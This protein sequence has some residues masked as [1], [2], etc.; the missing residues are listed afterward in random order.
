[1]PSCTERQGGAG[2]P[3]LHRAPIHLFGDGAPSRRPAWAGTPRLHVLLLLALAACGPKPAAPPTATASNPAAAAATSLTVLYTCDTRGNVRACDCTGGS[4]GG[5]ARR[6]TFVKNNAVPGGLLVDVGNNAAGPR[7]WEQTDF[8]FLL[9]G[10]AQMG[11]DAVNIGHGEAQL[12]LDVLR[13]LGTNCPALISA[14]LVDEKG[15]PVFPPYRIVRRPDGLRVGII[16][17]MDP[18]LPGPPGAGLRVLGADEAIARHLPELKKQ[19]DLVVLLAYCDEQALS[20]LANLFYEIGV[21]IGGQVAQPAQQPTMIN[22]AVVTYL[23]D[24]GK[25]VG[26]LDLKLAGGTVSG[27]SNSIRTLYADVPDAPE[28]AALL[29]DY[30]AALGP[31]AALPA[32]VEH[33]AEGL[34]PIKAGGTP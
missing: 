9:R 10:Y 26:R 14:S 3:R 23:T 33:D 32:G 12:P 11:Y 21:V 18:R 31:R 19:C 34:S 1:M 6:M 4:A 27:V 15:A 20:D 25:S 30:A 16:G 28:L 13:R 17:V 22:R 2:A 5:L 7:D 8:A 24:K 29:A